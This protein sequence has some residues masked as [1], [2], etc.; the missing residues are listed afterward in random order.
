M[1]KSKKLQEFTRPSGELT[2]LAV[3]QLLHP[4]GLHGEMLMEIL[5]DFPER[6]RRGTQVFLGESHTPAIIES[7]RSHSKGFL[8][9]LKGYDTPESAIML[10]N[11]YVYVSAADRPPLSE[12]EYYHHQLLNLRVVTDE[13]QDLG[14]VTSILETGSSDVYIIRSEAGKEILLPNIESVIKDIDL[15]AGMMHVHL[16]PGLIAD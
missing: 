2:Y 4:H 8:I 3:G 5:T 16:I 11:Q 7:R 12:G 10:V 15:E 14:Y 13:N 9:T 6:L 1:P